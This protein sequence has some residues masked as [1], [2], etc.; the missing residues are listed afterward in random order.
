M[1]FWT[2]FD[3]FLPLLAF[4]A[5]AAIG[6]VFGRSGGHDAG[7]RDGV[8]AAQARIR[9]L[10]ATMNDLHEVPARMGC[11]PYG[12]GMEAAMDE[13]AK[14]EAEL[15]APMQGRLC[16]PQVRGQ[17]DSSEARATRQAI[18]LTAGETAGISGDDKAAPAS[19]KT[20][21]GRAPSGPEGATF[22]P[23]PMNGA[24]GAI[25]PGF[26]GRRSRG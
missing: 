5:G 2:I 12:T 16:E 17:N 13:A 19:P 15:E 1:D 20:L 6:A 8:R 26:F 24:G 18:A 9:G 23:Y 3:G 7:F 22:S 21:D 25:P 14:A 4:A 11:K 10:I